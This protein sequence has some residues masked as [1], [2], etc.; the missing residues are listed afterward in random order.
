MRRRLMKGS[1][2][3]VISDHPRD[4]STTVFVCPYLS[5]ITA[6]RLRFKTSASLSRKVRRP[7]SRF[8]RW[9]KFSVPPLSLSSS[10]HLLLLPPPFFPKL[11]IFMLRVRESNPDL[12]RDRHIYLSELLL[13]LISCNSG[14]VAVILTRKLT[15]VRTIRQKGRI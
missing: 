4:I 2:Q 6:H 12:V 5:I 7:S 9:Q 3:E 1:F 13:Q 15:S 14:C 11:Y 10:L 8:S